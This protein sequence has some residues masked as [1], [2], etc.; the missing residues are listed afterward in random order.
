MVLE[1][2]AWNAYPYCKTVLTNKFM[3]ENM[4][5]II[6]TIHAEGNC[7]QENIHNL[8]AEDLAKREVIP[9]DISVKMDNPKYYEP[10][11]DPSLFKSEK[12][13]RGPLQEGWQAVAKP[14]MTCY[15]LCRMRFKWFGLQSTVES[16][17]AKEEFKVFKKFHQKLFCSID[18]WFGLTM[19]D[20]RVMEEEAKKELDAKL[21]D[22][23]I[24][25]R[26]KN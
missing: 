18:K 16:I 22:A 12:T 17:M 5:I 10:E 4:H 11:N 7:D 8:G 21:N 20:I 15:K 3:G 14:V 9:I 26:E 13:G 1:E 6:E 19:E 24:E 2:K 23:E 25:G